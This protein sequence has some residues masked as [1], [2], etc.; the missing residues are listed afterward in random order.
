MNEQLTINDKID[1]LLL[2]QGYRH[3]ADWARKNGYSTKT[4]N[5][6][7]RRHITE[8]LLTDGE[9]SLKILND[10]NRLATHWND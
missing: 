8:E 9:I 3:R 1:I 10:L 6:V 2:K 4:V 5:Q 7:I